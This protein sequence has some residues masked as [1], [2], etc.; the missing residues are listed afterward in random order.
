MSYYLPILLGYASDVEELWKELF[1]W[2]FDD[3]AAFGISLFFV[4]FGKEVYF[5][6]IYWGWGIVFCC[7]HPF[8]IKVFDAPSIWEWGKLDKSVPKA[9]EVKF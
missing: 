6:L 4:D 3:N 1:P 9:H 2:F 7:E 5:P 8:D